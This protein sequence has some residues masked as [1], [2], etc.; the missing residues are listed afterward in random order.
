MYCISK[1]EVWTSRGVVKND[2]SIILEDDSRDNYGC[3]NEDVEASYALNWS[4]SFFMFSIIYT[5]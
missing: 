1:S 3:N 4:I 2:S 5:Y